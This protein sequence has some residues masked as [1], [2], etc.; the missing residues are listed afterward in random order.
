VNI[1]EIC[2][3]SVHQVGKFSPEGDYIIDAEITKG[4]HTHYIT[5][6]FIR[7]N[8]MKIFNVFL[9]LCVA[10]VISSCTGATGP[11]GKAGNA[12]LTIT[13]SDDYLYSYSDNNHTRAGALS[14]FTIGIEYQVSAGT[15]QYS[16]E[17]RHYYTTYY[18]YIDWTGT[19]SIHI[20]AGE[21]G[22]E[23]KSFWQ[24]GDAGKNGLDSRLSLLCG[25]YGP[26]ESRLNKGSAAES[27][28]PD[29]LIIRDYTDGDYTMHV[30][31]HLKE[32]GKRPIN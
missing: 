9:L 18:T 31:Y 26:L 10:M 27:S 14:T 28:V 8:Y 29:S 7:R 19:Y 13:D 2:V 22:G 1:A 30:E 24:K 32:F 15:F 17:S 25:Y 4:H 5:I 21:K 3:L 20:N 6:A 16:Y 23:G 11:D 12:F